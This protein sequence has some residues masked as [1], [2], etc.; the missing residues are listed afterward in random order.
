M[1]IFRYLSREILHAVLM[2]TSVLLIIFTSNQFV[3]YLNDTVIGKLSINIVMKIMLLQVP[4]LLSYLLPLSLFFSGLLVLRRMSIDHEMI[5]L[6][7]CG[8]SRARIVSIIM[9]LATF[10]ML[11]VG[12]LMLLVKPRVELYRIKTL[13]RV[14]ENMS[15]IRIIPHQFQSLGDDGSKVF[16]ADSVVSNMCYERMKSVFFVGSKKTVKKKE[17]WDFIVAD[18]A[19][20]YK[21]LNNANFIVFK[22]GFRYIGVPGDLKFDIIKFNQY[23]IR[24]DGF[25][26]VNISKKIQ[27]VPTTTLWKLRKISLKAAAELQW[28]LMI[29]ISV[30]IFALLLVPLSAIDPR[31]GK[32]VQ[33][34]LA[35]LI[36]IIYANLMFLGRVWIEK[37]TINPLIGLTWINGSLLLLACALCFFQSRWWLRLLR[38]I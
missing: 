18:E 12:W 20:K 13:N 35:I 31:R 37:G 3:H 1:I 24:L 22:N 26:I 36:Y 9:I 30:Y 32:F 21:K 34:L 27:T 7:A 29:P 28:R 8:V 5:V 38:L 15:L 11:L 14:M 4:V 2:T 17:R 10:I 16:Y 19:D 6:T 33:I 25:H 23:G